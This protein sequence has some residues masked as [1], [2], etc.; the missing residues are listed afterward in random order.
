MRGLHVKKKEKQVQWYGPEKV[1][2]VK[3]H[4]A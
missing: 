3:V 4:I 2:T 1:D